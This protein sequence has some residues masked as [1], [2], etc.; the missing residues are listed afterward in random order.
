MKRLLITGGGGKLAS[1]LIK[2]DNGKHK[3]FAPN[4]IEMDITSID[5]V[6]T[7]LQNYH[8]DIVI[9]A[10]AY[11]KPMKKHEDHPEISVETNIIGTANVVLGCMSVGCKLV[12]ISTDYVYP[13][14][15][16]GYDESSPLSPYVGNDDGI[17]KYG[18]S[19]LGGECAVRIY[20]GSL[21]LRT[22]ISDKPFPHPHAATDIRKS[23]LYNDDAASLILQLLDEE[24]VINVGGKAQSVYD[25]A[26]QDSP[27]IGRIRSTEISDVKI[28]PDTTMNVKKLKGLIQ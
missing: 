19:K 20:N 15:E 7:Y 17:T 12:Y 21:I 27:E 11:T 24:G 18:W 13:G 16:G 5:S 23:I 9:H 8:P 4:K 3:I 22:C 1:E 28:A 25:F 10:G 6:K 26:K 2:A 14:T